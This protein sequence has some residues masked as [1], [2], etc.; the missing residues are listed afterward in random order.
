MKSCRTK[1]FRVGICSR[2]WLLGFRFQGSGAKVL[3]FSL[4]QSLPDPSTVSA[5]LL[6]KP[7]K[8]PE[9]SVQSLISAYIQVRATPQLSSLDPPSNQISGP[10]RRCPGCLC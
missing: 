3:G 6:P 5:H 9:G 4:L 7:P 1:G 10:E 8:K 2:L